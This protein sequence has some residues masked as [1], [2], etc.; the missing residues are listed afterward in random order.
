MAE[1]SRG[2]IYAVLR[3]IRSIAM[4][5]SLTGAFKKGVSVLV[6][7]YNRCLDTI[8]Q[9]GD[10]QVKSL[11]PTLTP[12]STHVDEVGVAAALL[13]GYVRPVSPARHRDDEEEEE[14]DEEEDDD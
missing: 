7:T 10:A 4:E 13:S 14:E 1:M 8:E 9:Q 11:F 3:E 6:Q 5:A 12:E 2:T